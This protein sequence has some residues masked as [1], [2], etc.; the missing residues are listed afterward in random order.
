LAKSFVSLVFGKSMACVLVYGLVW[1]MPK[2]FVLFKIVEM[3]HYVHMSLFIVLGVRPHSCMHMVPYVN[4]A[5]YRLLF[6]WHVNVRERQ[7]YNIVT[8]T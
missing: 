6:W 7:Q 3:F 4:V 8:S 5:V 1:E 2:S